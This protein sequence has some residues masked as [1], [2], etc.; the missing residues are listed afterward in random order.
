MLKAGFIIGITMAFVLLSIVAAIC[1]LTAPL[2]ATAVS[3]IDV[4]MNPS[5]TNV[6]GWLGNLWSMFW[7]DYPF[8]TGSWSLARYIFF[9][10]VSVG[11]SVIIAI[12]IARL[13]AAAIGGIGR[14]F[15][16]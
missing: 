12:E 2:S 5:I 9:I 13:L 15:F 16:R 11:M 8:L 4:L 3:R 1:E 7:F 14:L 10:P 6:T